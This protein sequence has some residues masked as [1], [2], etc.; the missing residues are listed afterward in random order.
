[1]IDAARKL[2]HPAE[3]LDCSVRVYFY[4]CMASLKSYWC[5][6]CIIRNTYSPLYTLDITQSAEPNVAM[7]LIPRSGSRINWEVVYPT[8]DFRRR[9]SRGTAPQKL[10]AVWFFKYQNIRLRKLLMEKP[11]YNWSKRC[12][13][14]KPSEGISCLFVAVLGSYTQLTSSVLEL[15][16][17]RIY[18]MDF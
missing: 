3:G 4:F 15:S 16:R 9:G 18:L 17:F 13:R 1:M 6:S 7:L 2:N 14:C 12:G 8:A 5:S 10:Y 11:N